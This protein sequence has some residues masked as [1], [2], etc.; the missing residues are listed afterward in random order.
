MIVQYWT[1][2]ATEGKLAMHAACVLGMRMSLPIWYIE[3]GEGEVMNL[4]HQKMLTLC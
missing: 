2:N 1:V 3:P 4:R